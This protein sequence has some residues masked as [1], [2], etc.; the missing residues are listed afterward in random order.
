MRAFVI[1]FAFIIA[2]PIQAFACPD[3]LGFAVLHSAWPTPQYTRCE[4]HSKINV[5]KG[6]E[7]SLTSFGNSR[8]SLLTD[9]EVWVEAVVTIGYDGTLKDVAFENYKAFVPPKL[10]WGV[11]AD[12]VR[13]HSR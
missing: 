2:A 8:I 3:W 10:T 7:I 13:D 1:A 9:K 11:L 4:I 12:A 5:T 6:L